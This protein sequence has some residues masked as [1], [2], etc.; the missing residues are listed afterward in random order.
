MVQMRNYNFA[1]SAYAG[2]FGDLPSTESIA[3]IRKDTVTYVYLK[4]WKSASVNAQ[5]SAP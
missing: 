1:S 5:A 3:Q 2:C 4:N